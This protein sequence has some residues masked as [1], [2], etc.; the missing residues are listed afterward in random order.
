MP[1]ACLDEKQEEEEESEFTAVASKPCI[2]H[3]QVSY[4]I[5]RWGWENDTHGATHP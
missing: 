1:N 4:R 5:S 2:S 3:A